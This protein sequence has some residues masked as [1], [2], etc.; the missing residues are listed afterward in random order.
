MKEKLCYVSLDFKQEMSTAESS[1]S[2]KKSHEFPDGRTITVGNERFRCPEALFQPSLLDVKSPG[3]H[4]L[5]HNSILK[6]GCGLYK[7]LYG[8]IVLSGGSSM[9]TGI[10]DR[11]KKEVSALASDNIK[12]EIVEPKKYSVWAG[13]SVLSSLPMFDQLC[14]PKEE[15]DECGPSI[16]H[17]NRL[18]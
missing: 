18:E 8:N 4:E 15:Y 7:D 12:V 11:M 2:I 17:K 6:C 16:V 10:T 9:F 3:I 1:S 14:I 13:G 5:V